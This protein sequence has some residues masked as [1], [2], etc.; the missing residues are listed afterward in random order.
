MVGT[1]INIQGPCLLPLSMQNEITYVVGL[2]GQ[3]FH[4]ISTQHT[5]QHMPLKLTWTDSSVQQK[6][7]TKWT[8]RTL[9]NT[10]T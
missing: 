4:S 5:E 10:N 6:Q 1:Q 2:V 3:C 9:N 8:N 7:N